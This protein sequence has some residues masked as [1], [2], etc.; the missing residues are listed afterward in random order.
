MELLSTTSFLAATAA[1]DSDAVERAMIAAFDDVL[2]TPPR[3]VVR[4]GTILLHQGDLV[5]SICILVEG[6]VQMSHDAAEHEIVLHGQAVGPIIGLLA[7]AGQRRSFFTCRAATDLTVIRI[8]LADLDR[9]LQ[10]SPQLCIYFAAVLIRSLGARF[11]RTADLKVEV[12]TLNDR[13]RGERDQL[14]DALRR[15]EEVQLRLV[16]SEKMALLGQLSAGVAHEINNP[17]AAIRRSVDFLAEDVMS[18]VMQLPDGSLMKET[19]A[20]ALTAAPLSTRRRRE[21]EQEMD[22]VVKDAAVARRLV[23]IGI[24][25]AEEYAARFGACPADRREAL[26]ARLERYYDLGE[27]LRNISSCSDRIAG[28]VR[29]LKAYARDER[30]WVGE[31]DVH[32]GLD[33]TLRMLNHDLAGVRV[34]RSYGDLPPVTCRPGELN[35]VWTNLITNAIHA[36]AGD[37]TLRVETDLSSTGH[38]RVQI[39]DSGPGIPDSAL[40]H[41]FDLHFTTR[42]GRVEF[43]LGMGLPICRQIISLHQGTIDIESRPGRTCVTV[44]LPVDPT[45]AHLS[46]RNAHRRTGCRKESPT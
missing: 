2:D 46:S 41:V 44:C 13:L 22:A 28:I 38:V 36:M 34:V 37:G 11:K 12:E 24:T 1:L 3:S 15:L 19:M 17:A 40:P 31:V 20:A 16:E 9:A 8:G 45:H 27:S 42:G 5:D 10:D 7:L 29:S 14:A 35:Q 21:L 6:Q 18:M 32:A 43:G 33:D 26:L 25:D 30:E 39:I 23:R 4:S